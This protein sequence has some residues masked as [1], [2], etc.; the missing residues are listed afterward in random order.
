MRGGQV[1]LRLLILILDA[2][3]LTA[4]TRADDF[5]RGMS[6]IMGPAGRLDYVQELIN[7]CSLTLRLLPIVYDEALE[8]YR[9]VKNSDGRGLKDKIKLAVDLLTTLFD[10]SMKKAKEMSEAK[11]SVQGTGKIKY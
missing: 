4:T 11:D 10:R 6:G 2:R 9:D 1:T 5:V 7:T 8:L 3:V